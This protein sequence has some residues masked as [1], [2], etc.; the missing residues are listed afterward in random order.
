M[1]L[2]K[3]NEMTKRDTK[4]DC[5]WGTILKHTLFLHP[6]LSLSLAE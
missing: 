4:C 1:D 5:L 2:K 3:E 6:D